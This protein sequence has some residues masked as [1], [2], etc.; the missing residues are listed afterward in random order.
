MSE[1]T[2]N[3]C[4]WWKPDYVHRNR[5]GNGECRYNAPSQTGDVT[6]HL[7]NARWPVTNAEDWCADFS[8]VEL[9]D[10]ERERLE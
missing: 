2:C 8:L 6:V 4:E 1:R 5:H 10:K 7:S 3:R 9:T